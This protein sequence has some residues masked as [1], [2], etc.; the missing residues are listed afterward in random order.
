MPKNKSLPDT[1]KI[2]T[3]NLAGKIDKK[4]DLVN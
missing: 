2:V 3:N 4:A 1:F